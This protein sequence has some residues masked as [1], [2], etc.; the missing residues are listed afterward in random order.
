MNAYPRWCVRSP[1]GTW[2]KKMLRLKWGREIWHNWVLESIMRQVMMEVQRKTTFCGSYI[3][4]EK[5]I[6]TGGAVEFLNPIVKTSA[7]VVTGSILDRWKK[8]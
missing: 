2:T 3:K 5:R 7:R 1:L 6:T 8:M 4:Q